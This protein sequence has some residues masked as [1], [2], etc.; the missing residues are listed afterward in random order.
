[1]N[2]QD[3]KKVSNKACRGCRYF[4]GSFDNMRCC[5]Y[6]LE[7]DKIRPCPPGEGRTVKEPKKQRGGY[8]EQAQR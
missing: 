1:M 8:N 3:E 5:N 6:L 7:T 2:K 4:Y